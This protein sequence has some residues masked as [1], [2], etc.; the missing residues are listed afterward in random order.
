MKQAILLLLLS[1]PLHYIFAG[2]Y[3]FSALHGLRDKKGN[4]YFEISGYDI[5]YSTMKGKLNDSKTL[6]NFKKQLKIKGIYAE[7]SDPNLALQHYIIETEQPL[8]KNPALKFNQVFYLFT[9]SANEIQ[10]VIF[11]T[12]NQRD[13]LLE[14]ELINAFLEGKLIGYIYDNLKGESI[15]FAGRTVRLGTSCQWRSPHNLYC[16]G[17]QISWSEFPSAEMAELDLDMRIAANGGNQSIILSQ[18]TIDILFENIPSVAYRIVYNVKKVPYPL[19]V[20]YVV[21]EVRGR[22]VSCTM[23]NYGDNRND[24]E[25]AHLLR[26]FMSISK[27]PDHAYNRFF[28][29][30]QYEND[31]YG[32]YST[33]IG[34]M[35]LEVSLGSTFTLAD[36]NRI[37]KYAPSFDLYFC[38]PV[39]RNMSIDLGALFSFPVKPQRFD[40]TFKGGET[41][42]TK[43][44]SMMC[45]NLR[46]SYLHT[47][48]NNSGLNTY[49]GIGVASLNTDILKEIV[50]NRKVYYSVDAF[51]LFGGIRFQYK[52]FGY[53]IEYHR[54]SFP[55]SSKVANNFGN[56]F[57]NTGVSYF[58]R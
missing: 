7:Y 28:D 38:V 6:A 26:Q 47:L 3:D 29:E 20:Y 18:D 45:A 53:F 4:I 40:Y 54:A 33:W 12:L 9:K 17:G 25:L 8:E 37:F 57:I 31:K 36:M 49:M 22:Y 56:S 11:H 39:K 34:N 1:T 19:I 43:A 44:K 21:Q 55:N 14:R 5:L 23:S 32:M 13:I 48:S 16:K 10:Y 30:P 24:F 35:G 27:P 52:K 46:Y 2:D 50:D 58:F 15:S 51:D 41:T 42:E